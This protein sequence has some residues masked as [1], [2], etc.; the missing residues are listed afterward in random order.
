[1]VGAIPQSWREVRNLQTLPTFCLTGSS[2]TQQHDDAPVPALANSSPAWGLLGTAHSGCPGAA[3][4]DHFSIFGMAYTPLCF[5][6][7]NA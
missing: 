6:A 1:M 7:Y 5:L 2:D 3:G 4:L